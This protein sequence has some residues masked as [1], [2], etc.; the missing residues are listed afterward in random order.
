[1]IADIKKT[2]D[3]YLVKWER[4]L[5]HS[6][7]AVWAMLTDNE[8][9][10]KWFDELRAGDLRQGGFMKFYVP[11]VMDEKLEIREYEPNAVLEFDWFG[12]V[13]RFELHPENEGCALFLLEK[14]QT[15]TEQTKKDLAGWHVCL[16]VIIALLDGEPIQRD[17]EWKYWHEKYTEKLGEFE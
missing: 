12:D 4:N 7:E 5:N 6:V 9:L 1:V 11:D 15:I 16:D 17:D 8:R 13:I 2:D 14:V 3:G 10:E